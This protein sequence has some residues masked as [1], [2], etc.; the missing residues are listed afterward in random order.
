MARIQATPVDKQHEGLAR[1]LEKIGEALLKVPEET[2]AGFLSVG[3]RLQG[4]Y[5][6]TVKV[7]ELS[8]SSAELL[9]GEKVMDTM[10]GLDSL[11]GRMGAYVK[12]SETNTMQR[13]NKL[14]SISGTVEV[15][16]EQLEEY[17]GMARALRQI[18]TTAMVYSAPMAREGGGFMVLARN[19]RD[20]SESIK[21]K[22]LAA[23]ED[24]KDIRSTVNAAFGKVN[25]LKDG[26]YDRVHNILAEIRQNLGSLR[27]RHESASEAFAS[28]SEWSRD[29]SRNIENVVLSSQFQDIT[30]QKFERIKRSI[31]DLSEKLISGHGNAGYGWGVGSRGIEAEIG[32]FCERQVGELYKARDTLVNAVTGILSSLEEMAAS[33]MEMSAQT[34][35]MIDSGETTG[36]SFLEQM[37]VSLAAVK[38]AL[39]AIFE[40]DMEVSRAVASTGSAVGNIASMVEEIENIEDQIDI[41]ALNAG[42]QSAQAGQ[43]GSAMGV[44]SQAIRKFSSESIDE[45]ASIAQALRSLSEDLEGLQ[46]DVNRELAGTLD[47]ARRME[48]EM[49][50]LIETLE[51]LNGNASMVL[52]DMDEEVRAL[53]KDIAKTVQE[54]NAHNDADQILSRVISDFRD[55]ARENGTLIPEDDGHTGGK[56]EI[57]T[58][59]L[60]SLFGK[61]GNSHEKDDPAT[62]DSG[63]SEAYGNN[64]EFF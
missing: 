45:T 56:G 18:G 1:H 19:I 26:Q 13:I 60:K 22:S 50:A 33:M 17:V 23:R 34:H 38:G 46:S 42:V 59:T 24:I 32:H 61:T 63:E 2:E 16:Q 4:Y 47:E 43:T 8:S 39:T 10:R 20:L 25:D 41:I 37:G 12:D 28:I 40:A 3:S 7:S 30:R 62:L 35:E 51:R 52:R 55:I 6:T 57:R 44:L 9:S 11:L 5:E 48:G 54:T 64:I 27:K 36:I 21:S 15:I 58:V 29:V 14:K 53:S 31:D 49:G